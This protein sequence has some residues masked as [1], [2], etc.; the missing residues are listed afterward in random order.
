MSYHNISYITNA[1]EQRNSQLEDT[2]SEMET[3]SASSIADLNDVELISENLGDIPIKELHDYILRKHK[4]MD[5]GFKA[6]FKVRKIFYHLFHQ[7]HFYWLLLKS[8]VKGQTLMPLVEVLRRRAHIM[9]FIFSVV[10]IEVHVTFH[11]P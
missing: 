10:C 6:E 8:F 2:E 4:V 9:M 1:E 3:K 5:E 11:F 7:L